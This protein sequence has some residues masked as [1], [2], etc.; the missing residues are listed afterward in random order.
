MK[1]LWRSEEMKVYRLIFLGLALFAS[2]NVAQAAINFFPFGVNFSI[3]GNISDWN[4]LEVLNVPSVPIGTYEPG[5]TDPAGDLSYVIDPVCGGGTGFERDIFVSGR[6]G[7][8]GRYLSGFDLVRANYTYDK[9]NDTL[10]FLIQSSGAI[11]DRD[12]DG[13]AN[14]TGLIWPCVV[15]SGQESPGVGFQESYAIL[16]D[17]NKNGRFEVSEPFILY[18]MGD[19]LQ[20][21]NLP[22]NNDDLLAAYD[23]AHNGTSLEIAVQNATGNLGLHPERLNWSP[24]AVANDPFSEETV[25]QPIAPALKLI[26]KGN[27][28]SV[29]PGDLVIYY[30]DVENTGTSVLLI[31]NLTD[32][33]LGNISLPGLLTVSP[34]TILNIS[35]KLILSGFPVP[36]STIFNETCNIA[37][38][39]VTDA[40]GYPLS[41]SDGTCVTLN[42]PSKFPAITPAGFVILI[43]VLSLLAYLSIRRTI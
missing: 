43:S 16:F 18:G 41:A 3:D 25:G 24:T 26:K 23:I 1:V 2:I 13:T 28:S 11:G 9:N 19:V 21:Q 36:N 22:G 35:G 39:N 34:G 8:G 33:K 5:I 38:V 20:W 6:G 7:Y 15:N 14:G 12:G 27:R 31:V 29:N 4:Q 17:T 40:F 10:L 37:I 30:Y 42:T 32:D